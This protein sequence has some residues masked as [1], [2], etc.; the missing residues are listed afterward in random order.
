VVGADT[1]VVLDGDI[2]G[3]PAG[4]RQAVQ[5]LRR[6]RGR[7]HQV[8]TAITVIDTAA[9][10]PIEKT[11]LVATPVPMRAYSDEEIE[12]YVATGNPLDQAGAYAIQ[13]AGFQPVDLER[14]AGCFANVMGL[15]VCRLLRLLR[16]LAA[17]GVPP[18][19][20]LADCGHFDPQACPIVPQLDMESAR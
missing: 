16:L 12:A 6:L 7:I 8:L 2:I 17:A 15:P 9:E 13:Y 20:P 11:E 19:L 4:P 14:F 18:N 1:I 5:S 10:P 3:K